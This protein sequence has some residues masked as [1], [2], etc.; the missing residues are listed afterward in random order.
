MLQVLIRCEYRSISEDAD[1]YETCAIVHRLHILFISSNYSSY[2]KTL[3]GGSKFLCFFYAR[4]KT[5]ADDTFICI[6]S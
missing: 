3:F 5:L 6:I 4:M 1:I 2:Y